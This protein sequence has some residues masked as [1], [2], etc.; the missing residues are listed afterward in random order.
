[1]CDVEKNWSNLFDED[2]FECDEHEECEDR[3][4]PV[5]VKTP[6]THTEHLED[7]ERSCGSL[8]KQLPEIRQRYIQ[9]TVIV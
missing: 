8:A 1:M 2:G 4:V 9:P 3:V 6:E 7:K 5:F